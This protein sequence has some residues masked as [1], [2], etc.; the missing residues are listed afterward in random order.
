MELYNEERLRQMFED[1]LAKPGKEANYYWTLYRGKTPD[2]KKNLV[3]NNDH[4]ADLESSYELLVR[5]MS[6]HMHVT[7]VFTIVVKNAPTSTGHTLVFSNTPTG[8]MPRAFAGIGSFGGG[9]EGMSK[10]LQAQLTRLEVQL[11]RQEYEHKL[12]KVQEE[13]EA[14]RESRV[15]GFDKLIDRIDLDA[16]IPHVIGLFNKKAPAIGE[17]TSGQQAPPASNENQSQG[18]DYNRALA[19]VQLVGT[20]FPNPDEVVY[21]LGLW[22]HQNPEAA[23]QYLAF[24]Q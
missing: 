21:K 12:E 2:E 17:M 5:Q 20:V 22:I 9:E 3:Y 11:V 18:F 16:L 7:R 24:I 15:S 4:S 6:Y 10:S 1:S 19:G 14:E 13:L 23:R 8:E